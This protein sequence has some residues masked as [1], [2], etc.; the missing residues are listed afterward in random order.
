MILFTHLVERENAHHGGEKGADCDHVNHGRGHGNTGQDDEGYGE[1]RTDQGR[2]AANDSH[3]QAVTDR[4]VREHEHDEH[5]AC[6]DTAQDILI[7]QSCNSVFA[8]QSDEHGRTAQRAV[9]SR[10]SAQ[11]R[12]EISFR[13]GQIYVFSEYVNEFGDV[14][15]HFAL[16]FIHD[17]V[18]VQ[19]FPT[20]RF[21][22]VQ[23]FFGDIHV[24]VD[25]YGDRLGIFQER[26]LIEHPP[27]Q[28]VAHDAE[29]RRRNQNNAED[30]GNNFN[31]RQFLENLTHRRY[32]PLLHG[33]RYTCS[34]LRR[35]RDS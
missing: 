33:N 14:T 11:R 8:V 29:R 2:C 31:I 9:F 35:G 34:C 12:F 19:D 23:L 24:L 17:A 20:F 21:Y 5:H 7:C 13:R 26:V 1:Q 30:H 10:Q 28:R 22:F 32:P 3:I 15:G 4:H 6:D 18:I 16:H 25:G 27:A